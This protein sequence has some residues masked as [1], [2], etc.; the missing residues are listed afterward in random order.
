MNYLQPIAIVVLSILAAVAYGVVHD[1]ITVRICIEYFTIGHP[2]IFSQPVTSPTIIGLA[3]GVIATW[4][5]GLGLGI[6]LAVAARAGR[7]PPRNVV[8]LL[9]PIGLLMAVTGALAA[10]AGLLGNYTASEG[11][12]FLVEPLASRVPDNKHVAF[13]TDLWIHSAS[14]LFGTLGGVVLIAWTWRS[15][16]LATDEPK[17]AEI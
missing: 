17:S 10:I 2:P 5:V 13:L 9:R 12:V 11:L 8:S 4:W 6:P 15:R 3:W 1:Q 14:Y 7:R 16:R